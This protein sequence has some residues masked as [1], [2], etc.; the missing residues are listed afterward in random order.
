MLARTESPAFGSPSDG[1]TGARP[2]HLALVAA[3]YGLVPAASAQLSGIGLAITPAF[4]SP[5]TVGQRTQPALVQLVNQSVG[6]AAADTVTVTNVRINPACAVSAVQGAPGVPSPCMALE[7]RPD[8]ALPIFELSDVSTPGTTCPGAPFV[9]SGPDAEGD[10][11]F[12]PTAGPLTLAPIGQPGASCRIQFTFDVI[13]APTDGLT[14]QAA[15]LLATSPSFTG[16]VPQ[17]GA[18]SVVINQPPTTTTTTV[19]VTTT[20]VPVAVLPAVVTAVRPRVQPT[21][22]STGARAMVVPGLGLL[23]LGLLGLAWLRRVQ[24]TP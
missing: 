11:A 23:L 1:G 19:P 8:P 9:I 15:A 2:G 14:F 18:S 10:Y 21:L 3:A 16:G 22:A 5:V 17:T 12:T 13:Q 20:T 7:P 24:S 4:Q 6:Q